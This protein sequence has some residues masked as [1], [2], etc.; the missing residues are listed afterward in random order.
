MQFAFF[1]F[2]NKDNDGHNNAA[3]DGKFLLFTN[4]KDWCIITTKI[5]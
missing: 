4:K 1:L 5:L 2:K 3:L